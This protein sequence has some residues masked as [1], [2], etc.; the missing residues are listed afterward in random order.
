[1]TFNRLLSSPN[2]PVWAVVLCILGF[3]LSFAGIAW[4]QAPAQ[5]SPKTVSAIE[6][7][8]IGAA[9]V[10]ADRIKSNM[11]TQPG[12]VLSQGAIEQDVKN[13]FETGDVSDVRILRESDGADRVKLIVL[14]Q[15]RPKLKSVRYVGNTS[16]SSKKLENQ[17]ELQEGQVIDE[18]AVQQGL[19]D[20]EEYY[21]KKGYPDVDGTYSIEAS[22]EEG[23]AD[24][25]YTINEGDQARLNDISFVGNTVYTEKELRKVLES[26]EKTLWSWLT[27]AG[28][29]NNAVLEDDVERLERFYQNHGY[30]TARVTNVERMP[31]SEGR[32]NV[33][34]TIEEGPAYTVNAVR[35]Q[36]L[37]A[38]SEDE[39]LPAIRL[40]P[41]AN[42]SA[43]NVEKDISTLRDYYGS[44]G[45]ADAEIVPL[46]EEAGDGYSLTVT[47][48]VNEGGKYYLE[49]ID[50]EGNTKT[51]DKVIR[52]ELAV[53]PGEVYNTPRIRAS[54]R[55]LENL[56]YFAAVEFLPMD[57]DRPGYKDL[58][59]RV[60][61]KPTGTVNLGVGF[62]SI[63]SLVGFIDITQSNFDLWNWPKFT[64]GG[65]KLR[66]SARVGTERKDFSLSVTEP[67]FLDRRLSLTTEAYF[68][69]LE[70]LSDRDDYKQR[71]GGA[72]VSLSKPIG[73]R[74]RIRGGYELR[75]V[76]IYDIS[77]NASD[78][79]RAEEGDYLESKFDI[80]VLYDSR[81]DIFLPRRGL[82]ADAG[83]FVTV[84]GDVEIYGAEFGATKYFLLPFDT[85]FSLRGTFDTVDDTSG[86]GVPIFEREFLGGSNNLRGFRFR[87]V[88]P[89]DENGE[90]LGGRS[91][92]FGSAEI[93]VPIIK[94]VRG[95]LFYDI[96]VVSEK[97]WSF[98]GDVNSDWGFG[99]RLD[100]PIGPVRLDY[101]IPIKADE[102]NDSSGRFN[103]NLGY[104]F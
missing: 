55:R 89:K 52:R 18:V 76:E 100:L 8:Y 70:F 53:A 97:S 86:G 28:R 92:A 51:Q 82:K 60:T 46:I 78:A 90:P 37:S 91:A 88:G 13:L 42:Y 56:N 96:G 71:E 7:R 32:V 16:L 104:Q 99:L 17:V 35:L 49:L 94:M 40:T 84:G 44:R 98:S 72:F 5:E 33:I 12:D 69:D 61:E 85:I 68:R 67:W 4:G 29:I 83:T 9:T 102:F 26:K 39:L 15:T 65:Q 81:D 20:I 80:T 36:G 66:I 34:F 47:Y 59:V 24:V 87:D 14:V 79:I 54:Q 57:S 1:M 43:E 77:P 31:A 30:L 27:K 22:S 101:G 45:Y 58:S 103:F 73:E 50:I 10:A 19:R 38:F 6:V 23:F 41:G 74:T 95:A 21:S 75:K 11:S 3:A 2:T 63:D 62:S 48:V 93:T 64:G 25:V